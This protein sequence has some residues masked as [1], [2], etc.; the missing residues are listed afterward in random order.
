MATSD[1][2]TTTITLKIR[3]EQTGEDEYEITQIN[4][5]PAL[6]QQDMETNSQKHFKVPI[7]FGI[8]VSFSHR[9]LESANDADRRI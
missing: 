6:L 3:T 9:P 7:A 1:A 5:E 4:A 8:A 2:E